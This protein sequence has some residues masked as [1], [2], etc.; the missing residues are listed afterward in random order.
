MNKALK[1][2]KILNAWLEYIA[3][4]DYSKAA[5]SQDVAKSRGVELQGNSVFIKQ[6]TFSELQQTV[7]EGQSGQQETA[8]ALSFPLISIQ[9]EDEDKIVI[10]PLFSLD[11]TSILK[12]RYQAE[13]WNIDDLKLT[14]AGDNLAKVF[15]LDDEEL[16]KL[17]IK[18]GLRHLL[19]SSV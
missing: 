17:K 12:G 10:L 1:V 15:K 19:N 2:D 5:V 6:P 9:D 16:E 18:D 4:D 3:L 11:V 8:W 7:K 13:G 14:E